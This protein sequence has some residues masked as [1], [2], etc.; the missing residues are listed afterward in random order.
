[1][2]KTKIA[3]SVLLSLLMVLSCA[4]AAFAD[5]EV[6]ATAE[7]Q[8]LEETVT[9]TV[10]D[11]YYNMREKIEPHMYLIDLA[12]RAFRERRCADDPHLY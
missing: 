11:S 8:G 10:T 4:S 3:L 6:S 9:V 7:A 2:K 1:M 12:D 5:G